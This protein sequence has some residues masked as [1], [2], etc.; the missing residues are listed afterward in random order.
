MSLRTSLI[1]F[2]L[3]LKECDLLGSAVYMFIPE[4]VLLKSAATAPLI[5]VEGIVASKS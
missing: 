5:W 3:K 1:A 4:L 2:F